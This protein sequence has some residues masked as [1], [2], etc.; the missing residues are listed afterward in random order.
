VRE[1]GLFLASI[2]NYDELLKERPRVTTPK[3]METP[4]GRRVYFQA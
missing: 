1:G 3:V 4:D 2:R